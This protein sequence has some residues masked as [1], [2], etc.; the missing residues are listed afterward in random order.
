MNG[1]LPVADSR[2]RPIPMN[3]II[4]LFF[5]AITLA[6][7]TAS[8]LCLP[9]ITRLDPSQKNRDDPHEQIYRINEPANAET[10]ER[11][12]NMLSVLINADL[13][14]YTV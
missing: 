6:S 13:Q 10:R 12:K 4:Q 1:P 11:L 9:L 8:P 5:V 14:T 3:L 7:I 2:S